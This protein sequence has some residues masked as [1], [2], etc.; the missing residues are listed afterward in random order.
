M[1]SQ[2][3]IDPNCDGTQPLVVQY[4]NCSVN[5][6]DFTTALASGGLYALSLGTP[7]IAAVKA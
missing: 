5:M 6:T 2:Y 4:R 7:I 3:I 1:T